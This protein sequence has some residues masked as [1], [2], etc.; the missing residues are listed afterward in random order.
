MPKKSSSSE[1]F[2]VS[3]SPEISM[4]QQLGWLQKINATFPALHSK[5]YRLYFFGQLISLTGTWLQT[6]AQSW[7]VFQLTH[8]AVLMGLIAALGTLPTLLFTLY[9]GVIVDRFTKKSILFFTQISAMCLALILGAVTLSDMVQLWHIGTLFFLLGT[10]NAL[11]APARQAFV[12][13]LVPKQHLSSAIALNSGIF[14]AARAIGPSI[15]GVLIV[16]T[17]TGGAFILNGL[18]YVAVIVALAFIKVAPQP[19]SEKV[20][21]LK[22]I[23]QGLSYTYGHPII[24]N[25]VLLAGVTSVFGWSYVTIMPIIAKH[26]FGFGA[27]GLGYL[28]AASGL[29]ALLASVVISALSSRWPASVFIL[30]GNFI[31]TLSMLLF[32]ITTYPPVAYALLFLSGFGL[33]ASSS[34]MNSTIQ[35][36]VKPEFRGR[37]MSIYVLM[38]I[39]MVPL[40]NMQI[41]YLSEHLSTSIAIQIGCSIVMLCGIIL[42][43]HRNKIQQ[44]YNTYKRLHVDVDP[45]Q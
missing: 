43:F 23:R 25:L 16:T 19:L 31:F 30:G 12:N 26:Q 38:F 1:R 21:P 41:G 2:I 34:M 40:G 9:G 10:V 45:L 8:S 22:A 3:E 37:V 33:I 42:F 18:S 5:N 36:I 11:D 35:R 39:G 13:E 44:K 7:L 29:G 17:G 20:R 24:R 4:G 15:A 27:Q 6:V 32:S 28:H 14:N